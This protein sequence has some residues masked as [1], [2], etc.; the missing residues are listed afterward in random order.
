MNI[1]LTGYSILNA[2][3]TERINF[4]GNYTKEKLIEFL[5]DNWVTWIE[6]DR[7]CWRSEF[8]GFVKADP[9]R[10]GRTLEIRC[11]VG[12]RVI[13]HFIQN[14]FN[15]LCELDKSKIQKYFDGLYHFYQFVFDS[16]MLIGGYLT[17]QSFK[18]MGQYAPASFSFIKNL[19]QHIDDYA[20]I[21]Q[22]IPELWIND[23]ILFVEGQSEEAFLKR[24]KVTHY[25]DFLRLNTL[26]Y[27][28]RDN[29]RIKRIEMLLEDYRRRGY[30]IF[31]QGDADGNNQD[32]FR[33][34]EKR[35]LI[36]E[37]DK[38]VFEYDFE[39]SIPPCLLFATLKR[40]KLTQSIDKDNFIKKRKDHKGSVI[41]FLLEEFRISIKDIK[42]QFAENV[43]DIII[44]SPYCWQDQEFLSTE[45]G[46][47]IMF[48]KSIY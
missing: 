33:E 34:L 6:C 11:E 28:G 41:T 40:M 44:K 15:I 19:R 13:F 24:L 48:V 17:E 30:K 20:N 22:Y 1:N 2:Y 36:A 37:K 38:F 29:K 5:S 31:I 43:A 26:S 23:S 39:S 32:I 21:I 4:T 25:S 46:K 12:L 8:C 35:K 16:E 3:G 45:L 47:F 14:T 9:K 18:F 10:P 7:K 42:I 27:A